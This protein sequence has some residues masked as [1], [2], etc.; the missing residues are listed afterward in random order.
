MIQ[1]LLRNDSSKIYGFNELFHK[2]YT[3][4]RGGS[5]PSVHA[6]MDGQENMV[7]THDEIAYNPEEEGNSD[8]RYNRVAIEDGLGEISLVQEGKI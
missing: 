6:Q 4:Q 2:V 1:H 8:S 5:N 3:L 7:Y